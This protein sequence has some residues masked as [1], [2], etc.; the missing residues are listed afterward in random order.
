MWA[1]ITWLRFM[2][3]CSEPMAKTSAARRFG[4]R[5]RRPG[6]RV[7]EGWPPLPSGTAVTPI[8][9][10]PVLVRTA[11]TIPYGTLPEGYR[12]IHRLRQTP[13]VVS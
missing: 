6:W 4:F 10:F 9:G 12:R 5:L 13:K 2:T 1:A 3:D 11:K 7:S 8:R